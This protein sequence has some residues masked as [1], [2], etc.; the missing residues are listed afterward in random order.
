MTCITYME[1]NFSVGSQ[2]AIQHARQIVEE[3][4][5]HGFTLTLR[6]LYYQIVARD[7]IA[8]RQ[9]EYK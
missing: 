2:R 1:K 8:N 4:Q 3:Y 7:L 5:R 9:S 6:Q